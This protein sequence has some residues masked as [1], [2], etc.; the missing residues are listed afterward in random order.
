MPTHPLGL[1]QIAGRIVEYGAA[2]ETTDFAR[3]LAASRQDIVDQAAVG[4]GD[5]RY[6]DTGWLNG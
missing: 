2:L 4:T 5:S 6:D 1:L 3:A